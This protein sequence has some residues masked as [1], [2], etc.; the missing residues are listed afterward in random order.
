MYT[1]D[2]GTVEPVKDPRGW[3]S[4]RVRTAPTPN[5]GCYAQSG[6]TTQKGGFQT[7]V[8][9]RHGVRYLAVLGKLV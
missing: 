5:A 4:I 1:M 2:M 6:S 3:R 9:I 8:V 7:D